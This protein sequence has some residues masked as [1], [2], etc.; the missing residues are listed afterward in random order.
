MEINVNE[1]SKIVEIWLTNAEK[2]DRELREKLKL[3]YREFEAK[4]ILVAVFESGQRDLAETTSDL[5]CYNRRRSAEREVEQEKQM[6][7]T[8]SI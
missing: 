8:M 4:K 5:L 6:G 7:M 1:S 3:L 2:Q